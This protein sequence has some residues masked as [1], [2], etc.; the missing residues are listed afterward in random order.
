M[1]KKLKYGLLLLGYLAYSSSSSAEEICPSGTVGLCDPAVIETVVES[2]EITTQ[3]DGAGVLTTTVTTTTTT[4]DI[5]INTDSGDILASGSGYVSSSKEGDMDVDW[6]G[7]GSASM[8]TG[9]TCGQLG[10][11]K[12]AQITG[13]GNSTSI[14]GV[15]GM[16]TT[17]IQTVN[18]SDMNIENGGE[19]NYTIKVDKQD[20]ADSIYMHITGKDGST[21]K[22]AG[23]DVLSAAGVNTGYA[24]YTGGF[25]FADS[26]TTLVIEVGGRDINLAIGPVFD[27]VTINVIYNVISQIIQQT[28]TTVEQYVYLNSDATQEEL[29]I[30]E[31]IFDNNMPVEQPDGGFDLEPID[32]N[33]SETSYETVEL[34]LDF[35]IE[36]DIPD[37]EIDFDMQD[38]TIE[39]SVTAV[40]VEAEMELDIM[41]PPEPQPAVEAEVP[42]EN[43][44]SP[45]EPEVKTEAEPVEEQP[46]PKEEPK[47]EVEEVKE[48]PKEEVK[49]VKEEPKEEVK[50][51]KE[52]PK[53]EI[54]V[55]PKKE[56]KPK[57]KQQK[58]EDKQKAGTKIVK[59][60]GDKGRYDS[61]NQL[62]TLIVMNVI[63]DTKSFFSAQK[64][65]QDTPGFFSSIV[66][67]DA[68]LS[69]N[70]LAAYLITM[71]SSQKMNALIDSQYK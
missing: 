63:S 70:N 60:M 12:C 22:F 53:E 13:S 47:E 17:F 67:P 40:D 55:A 56:A 37:I 5:V 59:K 4:S 50:E 38:V 21:V 28:I 15:S 35:E 18:I 16:G 42:V 9:S 39:A 29:D 58:K 2:V 10:T 1:Q 62:K 33:T 54:K 3:N 19:V 66:V 23:T 27:D 69:D 57:T 6:G 11:D 46:E 43:T 49:E 8:P 20:S 61:T 32:N 36:I 31:D 26:L 25:D 65:L 41:P 14:M 64:M 51:V 7:Q 71:G 45:V 52:E 44:E 30:V 68:V 34:E 48:E 24:A